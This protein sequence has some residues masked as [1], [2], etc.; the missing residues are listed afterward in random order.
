MIGLG[1]GQGYVVQGGDLGSFIARA[2]A[3]KHDECKG[4]KF[5]V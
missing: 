5:D 3:V 1:F 4:S 2:M